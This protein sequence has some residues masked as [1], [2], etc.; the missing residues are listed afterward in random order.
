[1]GCVFLLTDL[2]S[3]YRIISSEEIERFRS[4]VYCQSYQE[5]RAFRRDRYEQQQYDGKERA[6]Q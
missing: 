4:I 1:M 5:Y 2:S 6:Y 3:L